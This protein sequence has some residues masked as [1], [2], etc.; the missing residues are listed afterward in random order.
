[1]VVAI[2]QPY[3]LLDTANTLE[4]QLIFTNDLMS[5]DFIQLTR[6]SVGTYLL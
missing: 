5:F 2:A 1:M 4:Q 6:T 3:L